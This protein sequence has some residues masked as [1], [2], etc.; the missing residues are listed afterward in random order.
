[1]ASSQHKYVLNIR[2]LMEKEHSGTK[3]AEIPFMQS[4]ATGSKKF[5]SF[6]NVIIRSEN[7][8]EFPMFDGE[9]KSD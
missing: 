2:L 5:K 4:P 6:P 8:E 7:N 1:M 3:L 9:Y